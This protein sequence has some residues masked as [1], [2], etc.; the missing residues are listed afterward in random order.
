MIQKPKLKTFLTVFP[1]SSTT[2][3]LRGGSEELWRIKLKDERA[4]RTF[5]SLLPYLN[6]QFQLGTIFEKL[7]EQGVGRELAEQLLQ[8]LEK[9]SLVEEAGDSAGLRPEEEERFS[10]QI[11]FFSR[12][13][14]RGGTKY[15]AMLQ[16]SRVAVVGDGNLSRSVQRHL[17]LSGFGEITLLGEG[18]APHSRGQ[19]NNGHAKHN[20]DTPGNG[21]PG[22][23]TRAL[24]RDVLW[25]DDQMERLPHVFVVPQEAHDPRLLET[26]DKF[27]KQHDVP[28]ML[29]STHDPREGWVGPLFIPGNTASYVSYE[30]RLRG[31]VTFFEENKAF[32][33]HLRESGA[34]S[35]KSGG[36]HA[37][38]DLLSGIAVTE[39]IKHLTGISIPQLAG[40]FLT[41]NMMNWDTEIHEVLRVPRLEHNSSSRPRTFPW[42]EFPYGDTQTRRA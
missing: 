40:K 1:L 34:P 25:P 12:F 36:L 11:T 33:D 26:M 28:W 5:T 38:F 27:S 32:D 13:T 23:K 2:W 37:F 4:F 9:S 3:G 8:H 35:C 24:S 42:K 17:A 16:S 14:A 10:E 30:A 18:P 22:L 19:G 39:L 7:E 29:L 31:N 15:Q 6:G 20:G 21:Q 41:V